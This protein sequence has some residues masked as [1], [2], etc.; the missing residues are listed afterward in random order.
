MRRLEDGWG[1]DVSGFA[2]FNNDHSGCALRDASFYA[3]ALAEKGCSLSTV[4]SVP[5]QVLLAP[6]EVVA[7]RAA[8]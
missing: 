5:D 6:R 8:S 3:R 1:H 7:E 2:F 4:P